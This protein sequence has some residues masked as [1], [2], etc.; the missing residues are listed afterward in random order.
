MLPDIGS[1]VTV[2]AQ[3]RVWDSQQGSSF[4]EVQA[5]GGRI[6]ASSILTV[7]TAGV[8]NTS[9]AGGLLLGLQ[10]FALHNGLPEYR[11]GRLQLVESQSPGTLIWELLGQPGA[12]YL[13][14]RQNDGANWQPLL[15][16]A[17]PSGRVQFS[18]V[19]TNAA[20]VYR[21]QVLP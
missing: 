1:G 8:S 12:N 16:I 3:M 9:P 19:V 10:S 11:R 4:E 18:D 17:N 13:I 21:A 2:Q 6:G 20:S 5:W 15:Q 7:T 14:E